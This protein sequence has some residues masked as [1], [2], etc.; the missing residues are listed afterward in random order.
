MADFPLLLR[1]KNPNGSVGPQVHADTLEQAR[2]F[3]VQWREQGFS[4]FVIEDATGQP[5][6]ET[7]LNA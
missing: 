2:G 4:Q 5:V 3:L 7:D 6:K 1:Y